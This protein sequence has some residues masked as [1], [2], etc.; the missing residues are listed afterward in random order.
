MKKLAVVLALSL[1]FAATSFA[2]PVKDDAPKPKKP[3]KTAKKHVAKKKSANATNGPLP[4][5]STATNLANLPTE[6]YAGPPSDIRGVTPVRTPP[7]RKIH[8]LPPPKRGDEND[9]T[10]PEPIHPITPLEDGGPDLSTHQ[11]SPGPLISAPT[12]TGLSFEGIGVGLGLFAPSSNPPDVNGRVGPTQYVQ[13]NNTSFAVFDKTTGALLYGPAAGNTL[14][15]SLG[16]VCAS[17]NDGDPVVSYD[18]MAGRWVISQFAVG[19]PAGSYSHQCVAVSLTGDATGSYYVYDFLTDGTNFVDYPHMGVWPD[20]YYMSTHVFNAAGTSNVAARV[21]VFER[22]KMLLGQTAR[23]QSKDLPKDGSGFQY[24]FLPADLDSITPPPAGAQEYVLGPNAQFTNRTDISRVAVTWGVTPTMTLT[25]T[26]NTT[27]GVATAPCDSNTAAQNNRDCVPQP[28]P[29]VPTDDLDNL[30]R[31]YMHRL[32]YRNDGGTESLVAT[33][34]TVGAATT[35]AHGAIKWMQWHGAAGS[36]APTLVQSG[37]FD[38]NPTSAE[39]RWMPSIAMDKGGNIALGYSKSGPSTFPGIYMTGRL[40]TDTAGTMGAETTVQAGAGVQFSTGA[41]GSAGNRW[42]DY[43][44][45]TLDPVDQCTFYYTNE[46][47]KTNGSFNWSTRIA[48]YKFPACTP[49]TSWGTL[50]GTITSCATG[51][52]LSGVIVNLSNGFAGATDASGNYSIRVPAATYTATA[53]DTDRAC[54]S[55]SP[56]TVSVVV[57]ANGSTSQNFC[58]TGASNL[59]FSS[60]TIDDATHGNNNGVVNKNECINLNVAL[61][62]NGCANETAIS[63][64][65]STTTAGVTVTQN[66][67]TYSDLAI[68]ASGTNATPYTIQ[69]SNTFVCGT[70]INLTLAVTYASGS[71]AIGISVPTCS[72]GANQSIPSSSIALTDPSQPDRMARDGSPSTCS[73]KACPGAINSA[74]SRNYKTFNFTNTAA[75][76]ACITVTINAS[77]GANDIESAAYLNSYTPPTAQGDAAGNLCLGY[78]GDSGISGLG[79]TVASSQYSFT[80][81]ASS[82]FVVVVNTT[83]GGT[84]C[85]TFSGTVSGFYDLTSGPGAC[86]GCTPPPTPTITPGGPTTFCAGGSVTLTSSAASGNQWYRNGTLISGQ[87][88]TTYNATTSGNYTVTATVSG[89]T[90]LQ[91][92]AT[93]VTVNPIPSTPTASNTGPYCVGGTITLSTPTVSGATYAWTGP[94]GF[95]SPLQNPTKS[96]AAA[97]DAGT[98]SVTVTVNGCTSAAGTTSVVVNPIP[99]T[100]TASN[101][102]PYCSGGTIALTTPTVSGATYAWTGPNGFTSPLQNPTK[103]NAAT[104]DAGTYSVTVTVN[105]CTSAAGSTSV[106]VNPTPATPTASNGGPYCAGATIS[107]STPTVS[108]ATYAWSGPNGFTSPL[109]NPSKSNAASADAGTYS[110]TITVNGCPSAAGTTSVTVNPIPATP[111]ASNGGPYCAGGTIALS[112]PT[113]SGATYA[114]TGP[115]GFTSPLQN[116]TKSNAA[117]AD[118]GT[119]SVTV[120][121]NGCTSAAGTTSVV[122]NPTPATPTASNGGPYCAGAMISLSTPTVSG[123]TYS[124]TGPNSFTSALQNPTKSNATTADAGTYSVTITVNGCTSAAGSTSVVVNAI[125]ATPTASNGGPYCTGGTIA[126]S[127]PTVSGAT[128]AWTGPNGF[129]SPLQNPTKSNAA[130]ADAGT[131][132]VTVTVNGCTSAAGTTSVVVNPIPATP[133]ASNGGPYCSGGTIALTTP[134]VSGATYSWSGPNGFTSPLQNPT[135]SNAITADAGTYSVTITVNGCTSAAGTTSV[136]VNATP[137]TPTASNG[138]PYCA[139]ATISLSTPFVSGAT[140]SWTGPNGF[141]SPLQNPTKSN[142]TTADS[143][144]YSV[145]VTVNGCTSAAGTTSVV[146]NPIPAT[147]TASNTGPYCSGGTIALSTPT[148]SGATYAWTGPNGFT[149]PLQNPTKSGAA[150]ADAGTYS[151]TITVNGCTSAAGTTN[152]VVNAVPATPTASNGGPYCAGAT[153]SLS[154]PFVSSATY[155]WTGPNS[156]TSALQN[157]TRTAATT[158]DAGTYSVTITVNGC[159]SAAGTT[160]VTVNA[161]PATPTATNGGPYCVAA[162]ISLTTATVTGATYSWTGPNGFTSPLQNPTKSNATTADA[163]TYSVTITVNGCTPAAG[164]TSVSVSAI[165]STPTAS[166]GGPYCAG[167]TISLSTATVTGATYSWTGPNGFTS[168]LQN[169]TRPGSTTA[170]AGTYSVTVTVNG[171]SSAAGSTSVTVNAAPSTPTASNTGPYC[172]GQTISL[173]TGAV[174]G[175]TYAWTGPNGFTSALQNPTKSGATTSDSGTYSVTITVNGCTSAAGSTSVTVNAIPSTPT[176]SNGGPYCAG[177]T[178]SL[179]TAAVTG[180]TYAWTGPNGF[181]SALQNPTKSGATTS[182]AGTYSVTVTVNG[183]SSAAGSTSVTVNATPSTPTATNGGPYCAGQ[184][185]SLST[186]AVTGATYSWTGPNGFT[187]AL[188]NPTKSGAT[189]SDSGTYSVTITVNGCTSAAGSTSLAVNATPNAT[190]TAPASVA[191]A[192]TGNTASVADAGVG[193]T[194]AWTITNGT[195]TGG[196]GTRSITFTA[197]AVGTLTLNATV[198]TAA[199]CS[200]QRSA[201][202]TVTA[203]GPSVTITSITPAVGPWLGGT[204]VTIAGSGFQSGATVTI[205]GAAATSVV[206]VSATS[207]TAVTPAHSP[208]TVNVTVTNPDTS[209]FTLTGGFV[210]QPEKFD[211]NGDNVIDPADIFYLVNYLFMN[212]PSPSGWAGSVGS[213]DANGDGVVDPADI[214]YTVNYLFMNGPLPMTQPGA[215]RRVAAAIVGSVTLGTARASGRG[216]FLVPVIVSVDRSSARPQALSLKLHVS[217]GFDSIA[218]RRSGAAATFGTSFEVSRATD[219]GVAYLVSFDDTAVLTGSTVVAEIELAAGERDAL[220]LDLD[221]DLTMLSDRAGLAAATAGNGKLRLGGTTLRARTPHKPELRQ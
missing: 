182:D 202:V 13:W 31:H 68:D 189:T 142:A 102:G 21:Y 188:Q 45:M 20:G 139:G 181:T 19:G 146:V 130:A 52:P 38:P 122:V 217:G 138:G 140:Y 171:C 152:V 212:G 201:N 93:T 149:S 209:T 103:S 116:P 64:T 118:A 206:V 53:S 191:T 8:P 203:A 36:G 132:S 50:T 183:C 23:M 158:A 150:L 198:T 114:W 78:L 10:H 128:Y 4:H 218:I 57:P 215:E 2:D 105:G 157:P 77:C 155:S 11:V 175:A 42:G 216:T 159:P 136:V 144:T 205:G 86:P 106:V 135:K 213:G 169:P 85:P 195:I 174:T 56:A 7:L 161:T 104:A 34:T 167:Q 110:V 200:D 43:S 83:T 63:A 76:A 97:A 190:I 199:G 1:C 193:A 61:K 185:I 113:V 58:M 12:S 66:A 88:A 210:Y 70:T 141:T 72:G 6:P 208:A 111:T 74:G 221:R 67:S 39:Y 187:S 65:L 179:T 90:S 73:G 32:A 148:V 115:N 69:T 107:L 15:Q 177:Q 16:G 160:S 54:S 178:I 49:D 96:N 133:T 22:A 62:N 163:G 29:A 117:A 87:T 126:L 100:P 186:A 147:P 89:C 197:G 137:A 91:S 81:P 33:G 220:R 71:K 9:G 37:T 131:Y 18:I 41:T 219:D 109:Q 28:S 143:G 145:T 101:G 127:T 48:S 27:V 82:N 166:N 112:T 172:A 165:P 59:Q 170:D 176:P 95:T 134:T 5:A 14:F 214:F 164:S 162:T 151:V 98:Y 80:V 121:V 35:P 79:S 46:Y 75:V 180:A 40:S 84:T 173:S 24:G 192:A 207:I 211:P 108:G 168:A 94:N 119:Y 44:A 3:A 156:F 194:Y 196:A 51:A 30:G 26:T 60:L 123:A 184:T 120:T 153:I 55:S 25:S 129:T 125:P 154:T 17:H 47:L 124:W 92:S 204:H 99:A